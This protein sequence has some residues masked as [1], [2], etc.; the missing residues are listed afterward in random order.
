MSVALIVN[1]LTNHGQTLRLL[2]C[3]IIAPHFLETIN[4]SNNSKCHNQI[5][6]LLLFSLNSTQVPEIC[7]LVR[8]GNVFDKCF[9]QLLFRRVWSWFNVKIQPI[10]W[11]IVHVNT[12]SN[13]NISSRLSTE[14]NP[15]QLH[16]VFDWRPSHGTS[17]VATDVTTQSI[18]M[19]AADRLN[20][21]L[22]CQ[23]RPPSF[24]SCFLCFRTQT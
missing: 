22:F 14:I 20:Q 11:L 6:Q 8:Q 21:V 9:W 13:V 5:L 19:W 18:T 23:W 17:L 10:A 2:Y 7:K 3:N 12:V 24:F 16:A 15:V 4:Y 1:W